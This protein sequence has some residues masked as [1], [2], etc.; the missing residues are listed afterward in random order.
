M[1]SMIG[2]VPWGIGHRSEKFRLVSLNDG[3][4]GLSSTSPQFYS[5]LPHGY[6]RWIKQTV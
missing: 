1:E 4:F 2:D 5:V 6:L 3:Y